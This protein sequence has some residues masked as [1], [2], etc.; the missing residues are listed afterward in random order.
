MAYNL[1]CLDISPR[2]G[3]ATLAYNLLCVDILLPT[4]ELP[5]HIMWSAQTPRTKRRFGH[6]I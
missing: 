4:G 5:W 2:T 3:G 1:L 6:V